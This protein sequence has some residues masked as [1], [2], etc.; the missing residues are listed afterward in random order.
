MGELLL[1]L[2]L[3]KCQER[4]QAVPGMLSGSGESRRC[5]P[6][7]GRSPGGKL[8]WGVEESEPQAVS[9]SLRA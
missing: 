4:G 7:V 3:I 2:P 8:G 1:A 6:G 9:S 5:S